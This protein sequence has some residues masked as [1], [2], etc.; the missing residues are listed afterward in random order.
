[1]VLS[2]EDLR[3]HP[4]FRLALKVVIDLPTGEVKTTTVGV[5]R[6]GLSLRL[7]PQPAIDEAL[8]ISIE[9]P[10]GQLITGRGRSR[11]HMPGALVGLSLELDG[12]NQ[13]HWDSFVDEEESTGSLWRMIGRIANAPDDVFA[14]R[15]VV[16]RN[17]AGSSRFHTVGENGLAYRVAFSR[18]ETDPGDES[19]LCVRL[20]GFREPARRLVRRVLR[21]DMVFRMDESSKPVRA[22]VVELNRGGWAYVQGD[23][24][25]PVGLVALG[26][27]ELILVE[28]GGATV[29]PHFT[30]LELEQIA[31]DTFRH[32]LARPAFSRTTTATTA[33]APPPVSLP[34]LTSTPAAARPD[35]KRFQQGYDAVRFAQ[36]AAADVQVRKYGQRDIFFHPSVWAKVQDEG[37]ELIGPTMQDGTQLCVL[38]LVGPGTPRVVRLNEASKVSLLKP[39]R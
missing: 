8:R 31:C 21:E 29:F 38:A 12:K 17:A 37:V 39:P 1:M 9:L 30:A 32:D 26:V 20:P 22:R 36:A 2:G 11:A 16:E 33:A 14:P 25:V 3:L 10:S 28:Q 5:S 27:G 18:A 6:T 7:S 19:D 35:P 24:H 13:V 15:G 23:D 4:R 34:V